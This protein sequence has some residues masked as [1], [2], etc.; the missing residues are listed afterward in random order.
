MFKS[1]VWPTEAGN[2]EISRANKESEFNPI[3]EKLLKKWKCFQFSYLTELMFGENL[4]RIFLLMN[5]EN[6]NWNFI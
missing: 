4:F 1:E 5:Y 6:L 3:R 2:Q